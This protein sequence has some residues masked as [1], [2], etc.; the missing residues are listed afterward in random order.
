MIHRGVN[1]TSIFNKK[2]LLEYLVVTL[3]IEEL[4]PEIIN[5][6]SLTMNK[7]EHIDYLKK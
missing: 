1:T 3:A 7:T 4:T 6:F 5:S 2:G